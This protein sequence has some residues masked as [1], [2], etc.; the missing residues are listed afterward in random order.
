MVAPE[1]YREVVER[2][3][4]Q[5]RRCEADSLRMEVHHVLGRVPKQM[6][7]LVANC[8]LLCV[9]C[10]RWM[11]ADKKRAKRWYAKAFGAAALA[12]IETLS[13]GEKRVARRVG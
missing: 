4:F 11:H 5:C 1:T 3:G 8:V 13:R 12:R 6:V 9:P 7:N 2:D 10:H